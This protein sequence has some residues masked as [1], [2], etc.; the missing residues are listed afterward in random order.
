MTLSERIT[1]WRLQRRLR[2]LQNA[3]YDGATTDPSIIADYFR[4]LE[5]ARTLYLNSLLPAG[6]AYL[7]RLHLGSGDHRLAGWINVDRDASMRID[8]AADLTRD[9]PLRSGSVDLIH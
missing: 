4:T 7:R 1:L 5:A 2:D 6:E 8:L 9:M 3:Y